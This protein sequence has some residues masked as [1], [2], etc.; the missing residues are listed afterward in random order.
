[1]NPS[2]VIGTSFEAQRAAS[3]VSFSADAYLNEMGITSPTQPVENSSNGNDV[4]AF[5]SVADPDDEGVDV[6]LFALFMRATKAPPRGPR[7]FDANEGG[8]IFNRIGCT[9]CH[10]ETIVTAA[11]RTLINAGA[12]RVAIALG[13]KIIH[14]FSE[15]LRS[16]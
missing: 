5:D 7:T 10:T 8:R 16:L 13:H 3:L 12:L 4:S 6:E 1:M 2:R 14:P 9:V 15:F 11:P